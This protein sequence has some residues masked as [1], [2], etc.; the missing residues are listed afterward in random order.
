MMLI[1]VQHNVCLLLSQTMGD[2]TCTML[3]NGSRVQ[4]RN[5]CCNFLIALTLNCDALAKTR[6]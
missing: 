2:A 5:V 1:A 6:R 3:G 4:A